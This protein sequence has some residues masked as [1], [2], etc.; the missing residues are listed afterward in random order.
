MPKRSRQIPDL[1]N[2][3]E[4]LLLANAD[5][6][7]I[8]RVSKGAS[9]LRAMV[10]ILITMLLLYVVGLIAFAIALALG[11][12]QLGS[13]LQGGVT[14]PPLAISLTSWVVGL[15]FLWFFATGLWNVSA[16]L[17]GFPQSDQPAKR[18]SVRDFLKVYLL[19]YAL[20]LVIG[21][22]LTV[23]M[24][25]AAADTIVI[26]NTLL[27]LATSVVSILIY[28]ASGRLVE[29]LAARAEDAETLSTAQ[30]FRKLLSTPSSPRSPRVSASPLGR[31]CF[32]S[33]LPSAAPQ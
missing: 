11:S 7:Y 31:C 18:R 27:G 29:S 26:A 24:S 14:D 8:A 33:F 15:V 20:Q 28:F 4:P 30:S 23:P 16:E 19:C 32:R 6:I 2:V 17:P 1:P 3:P 21:A 12:P 9:R 10:L 25:P 13:K 22:L 5:P